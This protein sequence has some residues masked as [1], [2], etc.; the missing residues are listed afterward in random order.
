MSIEFRH[1]DQ[2]QDAASFDFSEVDSFFSLG[3]WSH[4]S[5]L[6]VS[7]SDDNNDE[8]YYGFVQQGTGAL[9]L[10]EMRFDLREGMYFCV[11]GSF[12]LSGSCRGILMS[13]A[14]DRGVF[15]VGGPVET[16]GRLQ[17]IDGCSDSLLI[18]PPQVGLPCV[19]LLK[20]P[21]QTLQRFHTHPS[22]RFGIIIDG[23]GVCD[24]DNGSRNLTPGTVFYIPPDGSHRFR[25]TEKSLTVI[26]FH[27]DSDFG[28]DDRNH[29]MV[30]KT[31]VDGVSA[32]QLT[33]AERQKSPHN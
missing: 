10:H 8:T 16:T 23:Q 13:N 11:P 25:T 15:Q 27:P 12:S 32:A 2:C 30:N 3:Y 20:I 9:E 24:S 7:S 19:N 4:A 5:P 28:P 1:L 31:I 26:A 21:P 29:P 17:Y 18:S 6:S 22:F 14:N 33:M